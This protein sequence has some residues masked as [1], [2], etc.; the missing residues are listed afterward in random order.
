LK[1]KKN[2]VNIPYQCLYVH[3]NGRIVTFTEDKKKTYSNVTM[4]LNFLHSDLTVNDFLRIV[5]I[6]SHYFMRFKIF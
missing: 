6:E 5:M 4:G 3:S 2:E 1:L